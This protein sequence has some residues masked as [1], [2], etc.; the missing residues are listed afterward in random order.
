MVKK[1]IAVSLVASLCLLLSGVPTLASPDEA[2][3]NDLPYGSILPYDVGQPVEQHQAANYIVKPG[4]NLLAIACR[5]NVDKEAL[6][7]AN[8]I[9]N[10]NVILEGQALTVPGVSAHKVLQGETLSGIANQSGVSLWELADA[11]GISS[12]DLISVGDTLLVP[13]T[14]NNNLQAGDYG[15]IHWP[16]K[17][18]T[19]ITSPFGWRVILG[20]R[21]FHQGIDIGCPVG[22]P[23]ESASGGIVSWV[24]WENPSDH[25]QGYGY[26]MTIQDKSKEYV[27]GH[28][29][30]DSNLVHAGDTVHSGQVIAKSGSTGDATGPHLHFGIEVSN[31][32][33]G[34]DRWINPISVLK[35]PAS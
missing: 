13:T 35:T 34:G 9:G 6:C 3:R 10:E 20:H 15:N 19:E 32:A 30:P 1:I 24:G 4:D 12:P 25:R 17:G 2:V 7:S 5:F 28:L 29:T 18:Y 11:N 16:L 21:Q 22:T 8:H 27:Y 14:Q 26:F 31:E 33:G 23:I